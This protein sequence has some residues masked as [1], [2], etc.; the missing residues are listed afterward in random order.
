MENKLNFVSFTPGTSFEMGH[1]GGRRREREVLFHLLA[2]HVERLTPLMNLL[3]GW[4]TKKD[5]WRRGLDDGTFQSNPRSDGISMRNSRS[6]TT[7]S[8][9]CAISSI[10]RSIASGATGRTRPDGGATS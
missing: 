6:G 5:S 8:A 4:V 10:T 2:P 3:Q 7:C 1:S 9:S